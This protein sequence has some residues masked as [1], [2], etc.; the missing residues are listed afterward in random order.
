MYDGVRFWLGRQAHNCCWSLSKLTTTHHRASRVLLH[1][2]LESRTSW[3]LFRLLQFS[4]FVYLC[5]VDFVAAFSKGIGRSS[6]LLCSFLFFCCFCDLL[7]PQNCVL[8][9]CQHR[10]SKV[11]EKNS[12]LCLPCH[13]P[14]SIYG[15]D[16]YIYIYTCN[17]KIGTGLTSRS[18]ILVHLRTHWM[19]L[20]A[21]A[22]PMICESFRRPPETGLQR[23]M[24]R[25]I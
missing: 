2:N 3:I 23:T 16:S 12:D 6:F 14:R 21:L 1:N 19:E 5:V 9:V 25:C 20:Q 4:C 11:W 18:T 13:L 17:V 22:A 8:R 10:A 7:D 15:H 24:M